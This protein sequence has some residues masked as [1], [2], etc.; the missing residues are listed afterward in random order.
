M[1]DFTGAFWSPFIGIIT[2]VSIIWMLWF[3]W[4]QAR[5][6]LPKDPSNP[7][8]MGHKWDGDLEE[9]NNPLPGWWMNLFYLTLFWGLGYLIAYPGLGAYEGMLGWSQE[10]QYDAEIAAAE[11][12]YGARYENYRNTDIEELVKDEAVLQMGR[13]LFASYCT[14]CHGSDAGGARGFPNLTDADW[15]WGATP[16]AI[17]QSILNGRFGAMPGWQA[18][19]GEDGVAQVSD[20]VESLAGRDVGAAE[21]TAGKAVYDQNCAVCHGAEGTGN[22]AL[23]APNLSDDIWLYGGTRSAIVDTIANG[24]NGQMPAHGEFLG[25][26]K[27][28]VLAAY[29]YSFTQGNTPAR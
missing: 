23:G 7:E 17:E 11:S 18:I 4:T 1:A 26:A 29:V 24:R 10:S 15:Q 9:Y 25:P 5:A 28:H 22:T 20:Y 16:A 19:I 3:V 6:R 12:E 14:Q 13:N 21:A 2:V 8:T 27:V